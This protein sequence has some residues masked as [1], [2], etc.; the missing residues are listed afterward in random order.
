M[1]VAGVS[2]DSS[3]LGI[4]VAE[5][6]FGF[7]KPVTSEEIRLPLSENE[8]ATTIKEIFA[9]LKEKYGTNSIVIGLNFNIF[10]H[11]IFEM[12][13]VSKADMKNALLYELEK[14]LPLPPEEYLYG[15]FI[16]EKDNVLHKAKVSVLSVR[17][18]RL[19]GIL[20]ALKESG[21]SLSG[22]RCSLIEAINEFA[23]SEKVRDCLF[24]YATDDTYQI[25]GFKERIP[26]MLKAVPKTKD[27][28]SELTK[29]S[30]D[31]AGL[32]YM[33]GDYD[34]DLLYKIDAR[35]F[36]FSVSNAVA[37]SVLR[38]PSFNLDFTPQELISEKKDYYPYAIGLMA[39]FAVVLMFFTSIYSYYK[40]YYALHD[41]EKR[42]DEIKGRTSGLFETKKKMETIYE[43]RR[44][45]HDFQFGKN[46]NIRVITELSSILPKD[47][48]LISMSVDDKG[49]VEIEGL[50]K[51]ASSII[52][53][54]NKSNFFTK[55]EF[56]SPIVSQDGQERFSIRMEIAE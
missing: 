31:F 17:K 36:P 20:K 34:H 22:V 41:V 10:S 45:L 4:S 6:R 23:Q 50:S 39:T 26:V 24:V 47:T 51:R 46:Q 38:K 52:E 9:G 21:L 2:I 55:V 56:I 33:A 37:L 32:I 27:L 30:G 15:F 3:V 53:P 1:K 28:K 35:T 40:D 14:Y 48:W 25:A 16:V 7:I 19:N 8:R 43:K 11:N 29:L 42:I 18:E 54:L 13:L 5:K 44:F 49:K 12:P